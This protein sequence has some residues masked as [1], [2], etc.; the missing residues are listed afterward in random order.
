MKL[1]MFVFS[2]LFR[3]VETSLRPANYQIE[4]SDNAAMLLEPGLLL[5]ALWRNFRG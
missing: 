3:N 5:L 2:L 1:A 4:A